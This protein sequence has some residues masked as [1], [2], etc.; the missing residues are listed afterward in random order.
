[1]AKVRG[2]GTIFKDSRGLWVAQVD[3]GHSPDGKRLRKRVSSKS[4][5]EVI[6]KR[7]DLL[8]SIEANTLT[9]GR[10]PTVEQWL[11]HWVTTIAPANVRPST[12]RGYESTIR[13]H[14]IPHIGKRRLDKLTTDDVRFLHSQMER[15]GSKPSTVLR[16][17]T[18]LSKALKDAVREG[19]AGFNICDRMDRP[20]SRT[21]PRGAF[22]EAEANAVLTTAQGD[23]IHSYSRW[24]AA[25]KLGARQGELLG[26][27]WDR[28]DLQAGTIDL[29][30]QLQEIPWQHGAGCGCKDL[31][32]RAQTCPQRVP[33]VRPDFEIR[34][35]FEGRWFTRPKTQAGV[36][37]LPLP[38]SLRV[39]LLQLWQEGPRNEYGL[40][41][42]TAEGTPLRANE[43]RTA[44]LELCKR[45]GV[46][47]LTLH[48]ARHT[49]V[50]LLLD[51]GVSPEVIRQIAGH[52]SILS[53]RNYMH[54]SLDQA[55]S[56]LG[57]LG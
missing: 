35:C 14:H 19:A 38:E 31:A 8:R 47:P 22:S 13:Q 12:L 54:V 45:A 48:A 53:T 29:A 26:L 16:A 55:R 24:L 7:R 50:S 10:V 32:K 57:A 51:E 41:W 20:K 2:E 15:G 5:N 3:L 18:I 52:S 40:V 1:M 6:R 17:H 27:E 46:R 44:W 33:K 23:G 25:L 28:V 42:A 21:E 34:P 43:D 49:M 9:A 36:R 56:A 30:W 37:L 11:N 39:A 4:R